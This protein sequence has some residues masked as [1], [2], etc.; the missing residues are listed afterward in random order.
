MSKFSYIASGGIGNRAAAL[1]AYIYAKFYLNN[2]DVMLV[3]D[4]CGMQ[5]TLPEQLWDNWNIPYTTKSITQINS[6]IWFIHANASKCQL[7]RDWW[8]NLIPNIKIRTEI[9]SLKDKYNCGIVVRNIRDHSTKLNIEYLY[10]LIKI[11]S[12][13]VGDCD[14]SIKHIIENSPIP[15]DYYKNAI[16]FTNDTAERSHEHVISSLVE[17]YAIQRCSIL[18]KNTPISSFTEIAEFVYDIKTQII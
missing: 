8:N 14:K 1:S 3:W 10:S 15:I 7:V 12:L 6:L 13:I 4:K 11:E 17:W 9:S 16:H 5:N 18:Y 2:N